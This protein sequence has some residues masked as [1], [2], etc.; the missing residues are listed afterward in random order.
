MGKLD[1]IRALREA[2]HGSGGGG[3]GAQTRLENPRQ[4]S[5][6]KNGLPEAKCSRSVIA[7][8]GVAPGPPEAKFDR[9]AYQREYMRKWRRKR[10]GS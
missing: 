10:K 6:V 7:K 2:R 5:L 9:V 8:A 4:G 3:G 1:E